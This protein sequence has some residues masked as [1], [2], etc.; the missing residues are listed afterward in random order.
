MKAARHKNSAGLDQVDPNGWMVT[1]GDLLMLLLTFFVMLLTMKSMD[2]GKF[3]EIFDTLVQTRGP[4][5]YR[6][7]T[8]KIGDMDEIRIGGESDLNQNRKMIEKAAD[9]LAVFG[10]ISEKNVKVKNMINSLEI[11]EDDLG[12]VISLQSDNLFGPGEAEILHEKLF[13]LDTLAMVLRYAT[14]DILIMGHTDNM[15]IRQGEFESN[16]EL[17][18]YRSLSVLFYLSDSMGI[19]A[20]RLAAGGYGD[21][22]PKYPNDSRENL[23]KNRRV[24]FILRKSV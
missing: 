12:V 19:R 17:S 8:G 4:L 21:L 23:A 10:R 11:A 2:A 14:N 20:E 18:F 24:E 7:L 13:I 16:W 15:P 1:F 3:R 9:I 5:E 22:M 6:D